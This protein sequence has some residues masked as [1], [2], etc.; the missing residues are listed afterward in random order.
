ML[1]AIRLDNTTI[2]HKTCTGETI[3]KNLDE[4]VI[5]IVRGIKT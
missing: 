4:R 5:S 2:T 1:R 3:R